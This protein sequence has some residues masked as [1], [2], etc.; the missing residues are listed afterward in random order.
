MAKTN[1]KPSKSKVAKKKPVKESQTAAKTRQVKQPVY[2][3]FRP[4]KR[5]KPADRHEIKG[6]FKLL[7]SSLKTISQH[8]RLFLVITIIYG[9]LSIILVRG[10]GGGLDLATIKDNLKNGISG[11]TSQL[12]T[13]AVLFGYLLGSS[14]TST[15]PTAST[16]QSIL[17]I[18]MSLVIIWSL[19]QVLAGHVIRARDAFYNGTY[20]LIQF[21]L[22][23]VVI[24][25]QLLP[26]LIGSWIYT[27]ILQGGIAVTDLEKYLWFILFFLMVLL[28]LYMI[29]SS[30]FALYIVTLPNM[31]PIKALRS[32]RA[33]VKHRRWTVMRKVLFLPLALMVLG[34][35]IMV[36]LILYVTPVAE[37]V[38]FGLTMFV[39]VV[40][41][42]YMYSLYR[43]LL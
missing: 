11:E 41:H 4:S 43:E 14:G 23:L 25:L 22:V 37:W 35:I 28:S 9:V 32:A 7:S 29:C 19:R 26:L 3:S 6:S 1:K 16:Y 40:V 2:K 18:I 15:S 36:P 5:I 21:I 34:A 33:L 20:P 10:I 13:G 39:L 27:V 17:V 12:A 24:G 31:T 42:S 30:L 38:F 8:W